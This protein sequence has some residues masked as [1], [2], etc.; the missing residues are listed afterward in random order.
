MLDFGSDSMYLSLSMSVALVRQ[1]MP[2]FSGIFA[3]KLQLLLCLVCWKEVAQSRKCSELM[4]YMLNF[5][6]NN[7]YLSLSI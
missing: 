5:D 2:H 7:M 3:G 4:K 6:S 1:S